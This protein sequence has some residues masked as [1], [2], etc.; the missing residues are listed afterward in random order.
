M[1][2]RVLVIIFVVLVALFAANKLFKGNNNSNFNKTFSNLDEQKITQIEV[3]NKSDVPSYVLI[4]ENDEWVG[5]KDSQSYK[6]NQ[7]RISSFVG[8]LSN[9]QIQRLATKSSEKWDSYEVGETSGNRIIA[10]SEGSTMLDFIVGRFSFDQQSRSATSYLRKT[11]DDAVFAM[12][13]FASMTLNQDFD[14][15][16]YNKLIE[17]K[18]DE[19]QTIEL[20][21]NGNILTIQRENGRWVD[22]LGNSVDSVEMASYLTGL[23]NLTSTSFTD[24]SGANSI[25]TMKLTLLDG[26]SKLIEVSEE[27]KGDFILKSAEESQAFVK[28]D[29]TGLFKK[30]VLDFKEMLIR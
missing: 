9:I 19:L 7:D 28:S 22:F 3:F 27:A 21:E 4:R 18:K 29:S 24:S 2:N 1:S 15:L 10:K 20:N 16:R 30:I 26:N 11:G 6:L 5:K 14:G 17:L 25:A 23:E 8:A 13:G 12:D